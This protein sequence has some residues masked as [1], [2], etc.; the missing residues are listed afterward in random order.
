MYKN[1]IYWSLDGLVLSCFD[2]TEVQLINGWIK[3][4]THKHSCLSSWSRYTSYTKTRCS[5]TRSTSVN[6][7]LL[8]KPSWCVQHPEVVHSTGRQIIQEQ[9]GAE[10]WKN[11]LIS[12]HWNSTGTDRLRLERQ[13][14]IYL[15]LFIFEVHERQRRSV[16]VWTI[17]SH[18]SRSQPVALWLYVHPVLPIAQVEQGS[19]VP[20]LVVP[21]LLPQAAQI[22]THMP[23]CEMCM[24][25]PANKYKK[26]ENVDES[27]GAP[28]IGI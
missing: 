3:L 23:T 2:A 8:C 12:V 19:F 24:F 20:L 22:Y 26:N 13:G 9:V 17:I 1:T 28:L 21:E 25:V 18:F 10:W 7:Y 4:Q 16:V 15:Y 11:E 6:Y 5:F 27:C 14:Q